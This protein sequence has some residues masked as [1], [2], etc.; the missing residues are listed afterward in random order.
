M[1]YAHRHTIN[2]ISNENM[3]NTHSLEDDTKKYVRTND[4]ENR[5]TGLS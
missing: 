1:A 3:A 5:F 2:Y 4:L